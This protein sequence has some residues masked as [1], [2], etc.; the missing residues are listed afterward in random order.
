MAIVE[1]YQSI[2]LGKIMADAVT[3]EILHITRNGLHETH[4]AVINAIKKIPGT[5]PIKIL[6]VGC[7]AGLY[8][9]VIG[10]AKFRR[11]VVY[12]GADFNGFMLGRACES[13][14]E[15]KFYMADAR[16]LPFEADSYDVV[17]L[18]AILEHINEW[19]QALCEACRVAKD[20]LI[21]HRL[22]L[23]L[24]NEP[25]RTEE[26]IAF[27]EPIWRVY[28]NKQDLLSELERHGFKP[29]GNGVFIDYDS[30]GGH[31]E[32]RTFLCK[33]K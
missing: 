7:G 17:L 24:K 10:R 2:K 19:Q 1:G 33:R 18:G 9:V 4:E 22:L 16:K 29:T 8:R 23:T 28:I 15:T 21:L 30:K 31:G 26:Q 3:N 27:A 13:F 6:D 20:Y 25:T 32:Q 11:S 14:P 12:E 5:T